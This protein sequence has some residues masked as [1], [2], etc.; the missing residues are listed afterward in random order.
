MQ[1]VAET[2]NQSVGFADMVRES[3]STFRAVMQALSRPGRSVQLPSLPACPS[4]L[5]SGMAAVALTLT[6]YETPV[7]FDETLASSDQ[8]RQFIA[9][10]TNA[11]VI[12]SPA[13]AAFAFLVEPSSLPQLGDFAQGSL[14]YPDRSTTIVIEVASLSGG[15]EIVL[16]GPG[17]E[18]SERIQPGSLPSDF[19][20]RLIN[21]RELFPCGVDIILSAGDTIMGLPR[22]VRVMEG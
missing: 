16:Q 10:H 20:Q 15:P 11:P 4:V 6:D 17:I 9:F 13:E 12:A 1:S 18:G 22:S 3:Q 21:N 2:P 14:E 7:W 8:V 19:K 5:P